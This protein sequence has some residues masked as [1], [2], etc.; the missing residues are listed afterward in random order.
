M[1][2]LC[3]NSYI[4]LHT[5]GK[6]ARIALAADR[7]PLAFHFDDVSYLTATVVDGHGVPV[8][9]ADPVISFSITGP[10]A[11][12]ALDSA[13]NA[14]HELFQAAERRAFQG[15]S[16]AVV[17]AAAAKGRIVVTASSPG[18]AATTVTIEVKQ[19]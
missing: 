10:G 7:N 8:P 17:K 16:I 9:G 14:S 12:A 4:A 2:L 15:R 11:I 13:D 18:L 5:A 1:P 3:S 6:P 19:P